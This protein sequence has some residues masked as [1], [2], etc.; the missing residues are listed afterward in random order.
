LRRTST[1]A[2]SR[3]GEAGLPACSL[4]SDI[5]SVEQELDCKMESDSS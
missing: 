3:S 4:L 2:I 1:R 5:P